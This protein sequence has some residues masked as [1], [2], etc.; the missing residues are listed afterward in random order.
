[1][2]ARIQYKGDILQTFLSQNYPIPRC[3]TPHNS[4]DFY[5]NMATSALFNGD[6]DER[7]HTLV[8][9]SSVQQDKIEAVG[10]S[11]NRKR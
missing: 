11:N 1:M 5:E 4:E 8:G 7:I 6:N 10:Q 2:R 3:H 9:V